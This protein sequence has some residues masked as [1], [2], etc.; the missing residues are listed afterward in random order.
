MTEIIPNQNHKT[1]EGEFSK[2]RAYQ[3]SMATED[4]KPLISVT[5][6]MLKDPKTGQ[7]EPYVPL[8]QMQDAFKLLHSMYA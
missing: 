7:V 5:V 4:G 6:A 2:V 8:K 1:M 3:L